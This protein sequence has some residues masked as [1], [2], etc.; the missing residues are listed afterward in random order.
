M[1]NKI[2]FTIIGLVV[3]VGA[4]YFIRKD[5]KSRSAV[6]KQTGVEVKNV[7]VDAT[8]DYTVTQIPATSTAPVAKKVSIPA[9]ELERP[10]NIPA[11][12][13]ADAAKNVRDGIARVILELK[14]KPNSYG[15]WI[16]LGIYRKIAEDYEGASQAWEYA[17]LLSP[18][19]PMTFDNLGSLYGYF[20]KDSKKAEANF[21]K[22]IE[23]G[24][25]K[26]QYY[27]SFAL[28]YVDIL[29]DNAK[30]KQILQ[31]GIAADPSSSVDLKQLLESL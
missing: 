15:A 8:G 4:G 13:S 6:E 17:A 1:K 7:G 19:S 14:Q 5:Y 25:S 27:Y 24:G 9:P 22:A 3:L 29:K 23:T 11:K 10:I 26:A 28:F 21:K 30:A 31:Q 18:K 20:L 2:I 12:M 16:N